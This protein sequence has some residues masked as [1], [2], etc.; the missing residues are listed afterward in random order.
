MLS[1]SPIIGFIPTRDA[2]RAR[3]FY[4]HTLGLRFISQDEFAVVFDAN[5]SMVRITIVGDFTPAP[6]TI[7]GWQ[8]QDIEP[9]VA[10]LTAKGVAFNR[11]G[12]LN[13]NEAGIWDAPG[14]ARV[15]WFT[16]PDGNTLSLSQH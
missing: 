11:Y 15:A 13:Q 6:F 7:F 10:E 9:E 1:T 16:D 12:F 4:E 2:A 8:V 5:G 14:G 3:T